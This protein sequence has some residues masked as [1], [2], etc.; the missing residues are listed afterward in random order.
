[1]VGYSTS[2]PEWIIL[3]RRSERL[4]TAYS[5]TFDETKSGFSHN[6]QRSGKLVNGTDEIA[7]TASQ[8][9]ATVEEVA[10]NLE[11]PK[12]TETSECNRPTSHETNDHDG[13]RNGD[14]D[15]SELSYGSPGS[16]RA[17]ISGSEATGESPS[18]DLSLNESSES[19]WHENSGNEAKERGNLCLRRSTRTRRQVDPNYMP[20]G[21]S[22]MEA[23]KGQIEEDSS[24][25][26]DEECCVG[27]LS[28]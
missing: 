6:M 13:D 26:E 27:L 10:H 18:D 7:V 15:G 16:S 23:L 3:D 9:P 25:S 20:S 11:V 2:S 21:T 17:E 1:M 4:R 24:S 5:V 19:S 28:L 12:H 22:E 14:D 8:R